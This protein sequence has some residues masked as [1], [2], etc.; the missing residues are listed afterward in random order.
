MSKGPYVLA[1]EASTSSAKAMV[2]SAE[3]GQVA[4]SSIPY[5]GEIGSI[6]TLDAEKVVD[7]LL[8]AGHEVIEKAKKPISA[9]GLSTIWHS[10]LLTDAQVRPLCHAFTWA[11][12]QASAVAAAIRQDKEKVAWLYQKTGCVPHSLFPLMQ[13]EYLK[14]TDPD[15]LLQSAKISSLSAYLLWRLTGEHR[16]SRCNASGSGM[17]NIHT[18]TWDSEILEAFDLDEQKFLPL[19]EPDDVFSLTQEAAQI[20]GIPPVPVAAGGADGALNQIGAGALLPGRMTFSVGTSGAIRV[21]SKTPLLPNHPSTWC[22]YAAEGLR[23]AGAA[24]NGAC[25]CVDWFRALAG[26]PSFHEMESSIPKETL[27]NAPVFLPF[28]WGERCPGWDDQ[29]TGGFVH[30]KG[31]HDLGACYYAILEGVLMNLVHCFK[32][33][34]Q[35]AGKPKEIY[36]SGGIGNSLYWSQMAADI[37]GQPLSLSQVENASCLGAAALALKGAGALNTLT[38][39]CPPSGQILTPNRANAEFYKERFAQ[40]LQAYEGSK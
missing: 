25:N 40:Y 36:L 4:L 6:V 27:Q 30:L 21:S 18:L 19:C 35:A 10:L 26:N 28:L 22:Y 33:L 7:C 32:I 5:P 38:D 13:L 9:I 3:E 2:Y 17:L 8:Q 20:L 37:F 39:F 23:I 29:R 1:L 16:Y 34:T 15:L 12:T 11:N 31:E 24:T 14:R